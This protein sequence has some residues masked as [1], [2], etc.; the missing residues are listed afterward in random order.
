MK[1]VKNTE[2]SQIQETHIYLGKYGS[3][4]L[5]R[6]VINDTGLANNYTIM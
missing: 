1:N 5:E 6:S 3:T 2:D 4:A